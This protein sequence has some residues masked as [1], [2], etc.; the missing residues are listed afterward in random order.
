MPDTTVGINDSIYLRVNTIGNNENKLKYLW[1]IGSSNRIDTLLDPT[2]HLVF[3]DTGVTV[4]T[5]RVLNDRGAISISDTIL[6]SVIV[7]NKTYTMY[8][9]GNSHTQDFEPFNGFLDIANTESIKISNGCHINC[10]SPL[11]NSWLNP[12]KTCVEPNSF[13]KYTSAL[14]SFPWDIITIQPFVGTQGFLEK[15]AAVNFIDYA[16]KFQ[17][18]DSLSL[19]IYCTWPMNDSYSLDSFD[20]SQIWLKPFASGKDT[21]ALSRAFFNYLVD[22]VRT[23]Y[24]DVKIGFI[25]VG[26]VFYNFHESAKKGLVPGFSGAGELYRDKWHLNNVG[27]YIASLTSFCVVFNHNP[28][29]IGDFKGFNKSSNSLSDKEITPELKGVIKAIISQTINSM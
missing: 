19:F 10:G 14:S 15:K 3:K 29:T 27:R 20:F 9:I 24:P 23:I 16:L 8:S 22:S 4:V 7:K 26:E 25:S 12:E 21:T 2:I 1:Q 6:I 18:K 13:G 28:L 17:N 5:V 11:Y